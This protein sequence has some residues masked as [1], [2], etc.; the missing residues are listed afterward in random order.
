MKQLH[1]GSIR[2]WRSWLQQHHDREELI[3]LVFRRKDAG[4][5]PFSYQEALDDALCMGWIDSLVKRID[6]STY[7]RKFTPRKASSNWS[8]RNKQRVGE[9]IREGRM[10]PPGKKTIQVAKENGIW[11]KS[12]E[13]PLVDES[14]P[15]AL[16]SAFQDHTKA[17]DHYFALPARA[18]KQFNIWINMA[19][20]PETVRKRLEESLRLLE[21]GEELGLK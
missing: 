14:L 4:P 1:A 16:L 17:R 5:V 15:G 2:E 8:E 3:W 10:M 6:E 9:L 13:L 18:Q 11:D 20:R 12:I 7:M 21:K 19:K